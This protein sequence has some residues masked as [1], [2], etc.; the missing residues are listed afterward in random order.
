MDTNAHT[1][2]NMRTYV[3][4]CV[5]KQIY[6]QA[7]TNLTHIMH[8]FICTNRHIDTLKCEHTSI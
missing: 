7:N 1:H 2:T 4:A 6:L 8:K 3:D 5:F